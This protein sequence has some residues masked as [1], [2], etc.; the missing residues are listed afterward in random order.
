MKTWY[1]FKNDKYDG[2]FSLH[3]VQSQLNE[4]EIH[5]DMHAWSYGMQDWET[6]R[7]I[8]DFSDFADLPPLKESAN[9]HPEIQT[10]EAE[11]LE[12]ILGNNPA[13]PLEQEH[14]LKREEDDGVILPKPFTKTHSIAYEPKLENRYVKW[15][16]LLKGARSWENWERYRNPAIAIASFLFA[17]YGVGHFLFK[18]HLPSLSNLSRQDEREIRAAVAEGLKDF[19]PTAAIG[20]VTVNVNAPEFYVGTN[21]PNG[22]KLEL[23]IDG[24]S[25]TLLDTTRI[26]VHAKIT[27]HSGL[28]K[29]PPFQQ[30]NGIPFPRGEYQVSAIADGKVIGSKVYFLGGKRDASY[31]QSLKSFHEKIRAQARNEIAEIKQFVDTL[32]E[33]LRN[34]GEE[35]Q[36]ILESRDSNRKSQWLNFHRRWI[37]FEGQ[38][39][40]STQAWRT[41]SVIKSHFYGTLYQALMKADQDVAQVH[42]DQ[43]RYFDTAKDPNREAQIASQVSVVQSSLLTIKTKISLAE[44]LPVTANGMPQRAGL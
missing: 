30:E 23:Q 29:S 44:T 36:K 15:L 25:D 37:A 39:Q 14:D 10:P 9:P 4:G 28:A 38:L 3:E 35:F 5:P 16:A 43:T 19:G 13:L 31:D 34:T 22:S 11:P 17:L 18:T 1:V 27:A 8:I 21:L 32:E 20:L 12:L 7:N 24:L 2:P 41:E 33:Q 6:L 26:S 40:N 42:D